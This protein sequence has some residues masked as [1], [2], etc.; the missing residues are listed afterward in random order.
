MSA[1]TARF[2]SLAAAAIATLLAAVPATAQPA[3]APTHAYSL[4]GSFADALGG[5]SLVGLGGTLGTT[6]YSFGA[7]QGLSL[8]NALHPSVYS[9]EMSLRL[10]AVT[11]YRKVLDF[12]GRRYDFGFYV[13]NGFPSFSPGGNAD[14]LTPSIAANTPFHLVLT[15]SATNVFTAYVNGVQ[16]L[17]FRDDA[18]NATFK[19]PNAIAYL[20]VDDFQSAGSDNPSGFVDYLRV[21]DRALT[22]TEVAA[23]FAAGDDA[24]PGQGPVSTVPEPGT[25]ALLGTGLVALAGAAR[26]RTV[27]A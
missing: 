7:G 5:P 11:S 2:R 25:W 22:G 17:S 3:A 12:E 16:R 13:Q 1:P 27:T 15:R 24:L 21:Y 4:N 10:D 19:E 14:D 26:R 8:S 9:L 23:R 6:G 20:L 18:R